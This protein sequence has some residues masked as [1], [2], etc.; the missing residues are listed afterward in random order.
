MKENSKNKFFSNLK[1]YSDVYKAGTMISLSNAK[2]LKLVFKELGKRIVT[3][4]LLRTKEINRFRSVHNF[5]QFLIK[6]T[7]KHGELYT[8]KYL[9]AS[10]LSIQKKLAGQPFK[11]L[12]EI[13]PGYN[14]PRLSKSGL[15]SHIKVRDR[16]AI[17]NNSFS[18][19]RLWLS[20]YSLY[21]IMKAPFSPKL[22]TITDNFGGSLLHLDEFNRWLWNHSK[23]MLQN[24]SSLQIKDLTAWKI[25]SITKSSPQGPN[26]YTHLINSYIALRD[27]SSVFQ[28]IQNYIKLTNSRSFDTLFSNIEL[29]INKFNIKPDISG[30]YEGVIGRLSFKEEAAGKLRVFAMADIITQS[31]LEPLH[32]T[33][34]NL[35]KKLP[36]DCTHDQDRGVEYAK[37]LCLKYNCSFGFDLSAATDR[38]PISSQ[39]TILN[40]L[41]GVG[42]DWGNILVGRDYHISPNKYGILSGSVRY[43]VGQPMGALSSWA[44]LNLVHHM[45]IQYV[46]YNLGKV[47]IGDWYKEYIVLGDD[48]ALFDKDVADQYLKL[49][50]ELGVE[51]NLSKSIVALS[52]PVLEFAKR[53]SLKGVDISALPPKELLSSNSFFGRL[54]LTTRLLRNGWGKDPIKI[55]TLGNLSF[56]TRKLDLIYP[57]IGFLVQ[58]YQQ[59][60]IPFSSVIG[61]ITSESKPLSFFGRK[62]D[63]MS[64]RLITQV[65]RSYLQTGNFD[66]N[67]VPQNER[68]F[69]EKKSIVLKNILLDKI[70][71]TINRIER[72]TIMEWRLNILDTIVW[73]FPEY[74]TFLDNLLSKGGKIQK[75]LPLTERAYFKTEEFREIRKLLLKISPL[76]DIFRLSKGEPLPK[77]ESLTNGSD[78]D[79][80][81]GMDYIVKNKEWI[82]WGLEDQEEYDLRVTRFGFFDSPSKPDIYL[83][84]IAHPSVTKIRESY[85]DIYR[86]TLRQ[87]EI[88]VTNDFQ[89]N[90]LFKNLLLD[91]LQSDYEKVSGLLKTL[92]FYKPE[93]KVSN[94]ELLDNPLKILDFIKDSMDP[95]YEP[96][97]LFIN[98]DDKIIDV[99]T[100]VTKKTKWIRNWEGVPEW[101]MIEVDDK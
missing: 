57:M 65:V 10:Q 6:M 54:A 37:T 91:T 21:R 9:K 15:P 32:R 41:F 82:M 14:F 94:A 53:T 69:A 23:P 96:K 101:I 84:S 92:E 48:L 28:S 36:N 75:E 7:K 51:I 64:P 70:D 13:E 89:N 59:R 26:S 68:F 66:I 55:L 60:K 100:K 44:M 18:V 20:L 78:C 80:V 38:L 39:I 24:F 72:I 22:N 49:C 25:L 90:P 34:F 83:P 4:S 95:K 77:L 63:W 62:I 30:D 61:L 79:W 47:R 5:A 42:N 3:L 27:T 19:I 46:A 35:F 16:A 45:M 11:S 8:I 56:K 98:F 1:L 29:I 2:H 50:K 43:S 85:L 52:A 73:G 93:N 31:L 40:A 87:K 71:K 74:R 99:A 12:K 58:L 76:M 17:I 81:F 97:S 33:L 88:N 67:L 86:K